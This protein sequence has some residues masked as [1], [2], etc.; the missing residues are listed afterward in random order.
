M[1]SARCQLLT[2]ALADGSAD[3]QAEV[4]GLLEW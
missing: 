4:A 1:L 3:R 2:E